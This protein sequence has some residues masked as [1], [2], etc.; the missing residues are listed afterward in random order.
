MATKQDKKIVII[1]G[2]PTGIGAAYRLFKLGY[3]NWVLYEKNDYFGGHASTHT[4]EN[5]F[6][7]DEG[8]HVLFS[9]F[10]YYDK[11]VE[12]V[13]GDDYYRHQRENWI[14]MPD[15]WVPYP[16][17]NNIRYLLPEDRVRG[18]IG[19][20]EAQKKSRKS[21][22]FKEWI[23]NTF[24]KGIAEIFMFPYN[25]KVWTTPLEKMSADWIA[26][27]VSVVDLERV[28]ENMILEKDDTSWGLNNSFIFPKY[29]GTREVFE[30]A[31]TKLIKG[32]IATGK[33]MIGL[34]LKK[35][36]IKFE[37]G[38]EDSY[39]YLISSI[40]VN[41]L[42]KMI[43]DVP[44]FL[45]KAASKLAYNGIYVIGIGLGKKIETSKC[46]AYF[47]DSKTPFYRLSFFHNYSPYVIP[48][49]DVSKYSSLMCEVAYSKYKKVNQSK[50]V[51]ETIDALIEEGIIDK[52]DEKKIVSRAL[53]DIPFA[54]PIPT[55][56][57]DKQLRTIQPF[58]MRYGIFSRG[59]FGAW[60]Y[61]VAN[62]DHSFMQGVEAVDTILN[63]KKETVWSL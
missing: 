51:Q 36:K 32:N 28:L 60:K 11:F 30:R 54:Y 17:Q 21:R 16:F 53:F 9:H 5:G 35:K 57:R 39:D 27:R 23:L 37:D 48:D 40:P 46:W 52:Q 31:A 33:K 58:L 50:V 62:M 3:K 59:R 1:G 22:N 10:K 25:F 63:N 44:S 12:K 34:N 49:G 14:K 61:E 26:E 7:W 41:E 8:G 24:G 18:I 6:L 13:L 19:L 47:T 29:G 55:L 42:V 45:K 38:S 15:R 20:F 43:K 2:G 4:D 56:D